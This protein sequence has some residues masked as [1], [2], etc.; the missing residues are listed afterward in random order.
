MIDQIISH[1]RAVEKLGCGMGMILD[2][3][4]LL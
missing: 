2:H 3:R 1:Y 4:R